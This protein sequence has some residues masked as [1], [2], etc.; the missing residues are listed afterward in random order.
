MNK[1]FLTKR[2]GF[3]LAEALITLLIVCLITL[4]SIPVLT[5]KKRISSSSVHGKWIC[6]LNSE[7]K[8][9]FWSSNTSSG[10]IDNVD[11]WNLSNGGSSC[12]FVPP[13]NARNF[14]VSLSGGGGGGAGAQVSDE[15]STTWYNS[16]P[17][18]VPGY[19]DF[20]AV[21]AG[22][23]GGG[24]TD[25]DG[26]SNSGA[27]G[28]AV[29]MRVYLDDSVER[30][31]L[32]NG[33]VQ[34]GEDGENNNGKPGGAAMVKVFGKDKS[35]GQSYED[36]LIHA[37]GGNG[38][39]GGKRGNDDVSDNN[40]MATAPG[41]GTVSKNRFSPNYRCIGL[42]GSGTICSSYANMYGGFSRDSYSNQQKRCTNGYL[43]LVEQ[44]E[45]NKFF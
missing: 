34:T 26:K 36:L 38:G 14:A 32:I 40:R 42:S 37:G 33:A 45:L 35:T 30:V 44:Q 9:V 24:T 39:K 16:F 5:K 10:D 15:S 43:G 7:N 31:E 22:G 6:T 3:S 29:A 11:T 18:N 2:F 17:V 8:H 4:A 20:L 21:G 27:Q 25:S 28:A 23:T 1:I 19:Y 13:Q 41:T 12:T